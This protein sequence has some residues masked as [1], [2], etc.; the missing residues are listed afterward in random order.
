LITKVLLAGMLE[1]MH[2]S[3]EENHRVHGRALRAVLLVPAHGRSVIVMPQGEPYAVPVTQMLARIARDS[4]VV[5][6][7]A[8]GEVWITLNQ[9]PA[10]MRHG[11]HR[12]PSRMEAVYSTVVWPRGHVVDSR[13][14][15]IRRLGD[16]PTDLE[17]VDTLQLPAHFANRERDW[18]LS[19]L[20]GA[21]AAPGN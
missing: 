8:T 10:D 4:R 9:A 7:V 14:T 12:G 20:P 3:A 1:T 5:A 6:A 21:D 11:P 19:I 15:A 18:L 17:P 2:K 13:A 16:G